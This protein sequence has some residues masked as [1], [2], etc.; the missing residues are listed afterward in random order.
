[1]K[2]VIPTTSVAVLGA[3][4]WG[5]ALA[6]LLADLG[7]DVRLW[8]RDRRQVADIVAERENRR[9]LPGRILPES[10]RI[11]SELPGAVAGVELA[12]LALPTASVRNAASALGAARSGP[13]TV[14]S[15]SKGLEETSR[16]TLD[17][18]LEEA[19]PGAPVVLLSG[20][21]FAEEI[22]RGLPAAAVVAGRDRAALATVQRVLSSESFRVYTSGD[23]IGVAIGGALKNV[24]AI[25]AGCAD[26][27]GFGSNA[28]AALIT[29]GLNEMGRLA[30]RLGGDPLTLAGLAGLGDLVLTCTGELS[31][32]RK[33]GFALASGEPLPTIIARLGHVAEGV[34]TARIAVDLARELGVEMPITGAVASVLAGQCSAR[35]AV[36]SLLAR[37]S[38]SERD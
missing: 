26:G 17:R 22:A 11:T 34:Y 32:N 23:V 4:A 36:A 38:G 31:R 1:M 13:L 25:A 9:Y 18:V 10:V 37:E 24:I 16:M 2:E 28:R 3:G 33:V 35:T 15:A 30:T 7:H 8:G 21:T 12:I 6:A 5:T 14:V 19:V 20:P 29:R 27:L